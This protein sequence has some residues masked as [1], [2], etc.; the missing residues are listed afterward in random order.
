MSSSISPSFIAVVPRSRL[1]FI[2]PFSGGGLSR[3]SNC[4]MADKR[5]ISHLSQR[6][7]EKRNCRDFVGSCSRFFGRWVS[8]RHT[9][10]EYNEIL[11]K[12]IQRLRST[13]HRPDQ[14]TVLV[15]QIP[16]CEEHGAHG[17]SVEHFFSKHHPHSY[18]SY[19]K[20]Y[21][22]KDLQDLLELPVAF[23]TFKSRWGAALAAQSQQHSHPLRWITERAPEP[24][25]VY[26]RNLAISYKIMPFYKIGVIFAAYLLTIF[27]TV[28]VTA[29]QGIARFEKLKKWFPPAMAIELIPGLSSVL[30]GYLPSVILNG[31]IYIVP[32]AMLG[33]AKLGGSI[34]NSKADFFM[35]YTL[36]GLSGFCLEALQAGM[37]LLDF[38]KSQTCGRSKENPYLYSLPY[39][40]VIPLV[41]LSILIGMVY[42]VV[43]PL[44]L[45]FLVGY[46]FL[47]YAVY[48]NQI[49]DVYETIYDT[50]GRY[51]P[52]I[53]HYIFV[54]LIL[55]QITMIGLVGLKMKPAASVAT[56]P[57]LFLTV[58]FNEYC[59]IRILPTFVRYSIENAVEN[60]E[61]DEERGQLEVNYKSAARAYC[62]PSLQP[63]NA[64]SEKV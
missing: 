7:W 35:T 56:F 63:R 41:S 16:F 10:L 24:R 21:T 9:P 22:G 54:G 64:V 38:I 1:A 3:D 26:W 43:A 31:F 60:D 17:C 28:P 12:R 11:I 51:W 13:R 58:I 49:Q 32:F 37:L 15:R 6:F 8:A 62:Q 55:M 44:L 20:L 39:F 61:A 42:A 14:F 19:Q 53:H 2:P 30:T 23:V 45:P 47:G 27:F 34:S 40:R 36:V 57:L 29:V 25:D 52:Y 50:C 59:K 4:Y 46:F 33:I 48:I 18:Y 5:G